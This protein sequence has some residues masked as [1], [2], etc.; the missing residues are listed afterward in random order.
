[1][2]YHTIPSKKA[3]IRQLILMVSSCFLTLYAI[4]VLG[5]TQP[6][7][8]S[9]TSYNFLLE[10]TLTKINTTY[11]KSGFSADF[12]QESLLKA[13][14]MTDTA[15]GKAFFKKPGKMRWEYQQPDPQFFISNG[16]TLWVYS[17]EDNNVII[18]EHPSNFDFLTDMSIFREKYNTS[19]VD[20]NQKG[21]I[22]I[23]LVTKEEDANIGKIYLI[24]E[25]KSSLITEIISFNANDDETK[26]KFSNYSFDPNLDDSMFNF[27]IPE[28]TDIIR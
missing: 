4:P 22:K 21:Q 13:I 25:E 11:S 1:M 23:E 2:E 8:Q 24:V 9:E 18:G 6:K 12:H 19:I 5:E 7:A 10:E 17:P 15:S 20:K 14:G 16:K 28:G 26:I 27:K 3:F